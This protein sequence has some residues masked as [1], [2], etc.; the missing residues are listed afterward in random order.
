MDQF[1]SQLANNLENGYTAGVPDH[2]IQIYKELSAWCELI[3]YKID[4]D[5]NTQDN[6]RKQVLSNNLLKHIQGL[7]QEKV[8]EFYMVRRDEV[9][10][11]LSKVFQNRISNNQRMIESKDI[12]EENPY[13]NVYSLPTNEEYFNDNDSSSEE[14]YYQD[15]DTNNH[16]EDDKSKMVVVVKYNTKPKENKIAEDYIDFDDEYEF[17]YG[18]DNYDDYNEYDEY[19][20]HHYKEANVTKVSISYTSVEAKETMSNDYRDPH[21]YKEYYERPV[22][23]SI[24]DLQSSYEDVDSSCN[25]NYLNHNTWDTYNDNYYCNESVDDSSDNCLSY[26]E[27]LIKQQKMEKGEEEE[28]EVEEK[29]ISYTEQLIKEQIKLN[30]VSFAS[31]NEENEKELEVNEKTNDSSTQE[32]S[33]PVNDIIK[34]E[35]IDQSL[36][37]NDSIKEG[38]INQSMHKTDERCK[39]SITI[40]DSM[41]NVIFHEEES[42]KNKESMYEEHLYPRVEKS[43]DIYYDE[44]GQDSPSADSVISPNEEMLL[45]STTDDDLFEYSSKKVLMTPLSTDILSYA[46]GL[47]DS[48]LVNDNKTKELSPLKEEFTDNENIVIKEDIELSTEE[49][50]NEDMVIKE[51]MELKNQLKTAKVMLPPNKHIDFEKEGNKEEN[52]AKYLSN[53]RD[54]GFS[55]TCDEP[56]IHY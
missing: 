56:F 45:S 7:W 39:L 1:S 19:D 11:N 24:P 49:L 37:V 10:D 15:I 13:N 54:S 14:D 8:S 30:Y 9:R 2:L 43:R 41:R 31:I 50:T 16:I 38:E 53:R 23:P 47:Y 4:V 18:N 52:F 21:Q 35:E 20:L 25:T 34:E 44:Y 32:S 36:P 5:I 27:Q 3:Q 42:I 28:K 22:T 40:D 48:D 51:E 26:T 29:D 55:E 17:D 12:M 33:L 46:E 6:I